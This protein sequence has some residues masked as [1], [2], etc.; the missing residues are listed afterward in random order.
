MIPETIASNSELRPLTE[1]DYDGLGARWLTRELADA[2][3]LRRVTS[4]YGSELIGRVGRAGDY[5]GLAIPYLWPGEPHVVLWRLRRDHPDMQAGSDGVLRPRQKYLSPP[6]G[7]NRLYL[8]PQTELAQLNAAHVPIVI[9]EGEF[10]TLALWRLAWH[11]L[12]DA[13]EAPAFLPIGLQGVWNFQG[14]IGKT[15]SEDGERVDV[16]GPIPDL[17]RLEWKDRRVIILFDSDAAKNADVVRARKALSFELEDRGAAVAWYLWPK[18]VPD[19]Q[20]GI[21]DF[22]AANGP[23]RVLRIL[24]RAKTRRNRRSKVPTVAAAVQGEDAWTRLLLCG[25]KGIKPL[26][27]N[28]MTA[29]REAP[30]WSGGIAYNEF[31][32]RAEL[33]EGCPWRAE[34]G[35][36]TDVDDVMLAEW[37][38]RHGVEVSVT[39]SSQAAEAVAREHCYHPVREFLE[40]TPWDG[41]PRIDHWLTKYFGAADTEYVRAVAARWL[42]SGIARVMDP[43]CQVDYT[44]VFVGEQRT[45]KSSAL[46]ALTGDDAW[47]TDEVGELGTPDAAMQLLGKWIIELGELSQVVGSRAENETTKAWLTRRFDHFRP[48][49]GRRA[50]DYP[51]QCIFAG[52]TN[53]DVFFRDETGNERYWPIDSPVDSVDIGGLASQR[54]Q[55][56]AEA[57]YRWS[58]GEK[59]WLWEPHL[60]EAAREEQDARLQRDPWDGPVWEYVVSRRNDWLAGGRNPAEA[61]T[62]TMADIL[63]GALKKREG[64]WS[65]Q[66]DQRIRAIL[67][68]H[69]MVWSRDRVRDANDEPV[70]DPKGKQRREY[71]FKWPV[72]A[73]AKTEK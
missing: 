57:R 72:L 59:W 73:K 12:G 45:G 20:K 16:R 27:A 2:A 33:P 54:E 50:A 63:L 60:R 68:T 47:F 69:G 4:L 56:W 19:T 40:R 26:L 66:D 18:D 41:Q 11:G 25:D 52:T 10:K 8:A 46:R 51:R 48:P 58:N 65:R 23:E 53:S 15:E 24:S 44:L 43:G 42:I 9:T 22:L 13:A 21:D 67:R 34:P 32:M 28:A 49:Y 64:E 38:Q 29:L 7:A 3:F 71:H 31:S 6:G 70:L 1:K 5:G 62:V 35:L 39:I 14:V 61:F 36:W 17:S 30:E 55:I 37:L